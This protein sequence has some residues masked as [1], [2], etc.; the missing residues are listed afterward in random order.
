MVDVVEDMDW[1]A[2]DTL[3]DEPKFTIG[4]VLSDE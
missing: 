3:L 4:S 1:D 2:E